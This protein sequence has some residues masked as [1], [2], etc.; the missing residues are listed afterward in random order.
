M[1]FLSELFKPSQKPKSY[2]K[3]GDVLKKIMTT[4]DQRLEA[5]QALE[6]LAPEHSIPQLLKRFEIVVDS[7]LIDNREKEMCMKII[8][9][10]A[11]KAHE[12]IKQAIII[13]K[14][15]AWPIRIAEKIFSQEEYIN[16][17]LEN[18]NSDMEVF[19]EDSLERNAEILLALREIHD[20]KIVNKAQEFL[21]CRD[22]TVRMA[23]LECI[24]NQVHFISRAKEIILNLMKTPVTDDN[25]RFIGVVNEITKKH[26][27][28]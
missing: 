23:A 1:G 7:G 13:Q 26:N 28:I 14:R 20:E 4:K 21:S 19:D 10:H 24:E 2:D 11:E 17:L 15:L 12:Y 18:L 6:H 5:I 9:S 22:E 8:V 16:L 25:S 3:Y 27:W